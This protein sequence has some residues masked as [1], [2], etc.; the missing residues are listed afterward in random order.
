[1]L[2]AQG[3]MDLLVELNVRVDFVKHGNGSVK[4]SESALCLVGVTSLR[5][6]LTTHFDGLPTAASVV[7]NE[8]LKSNDC[9]GSTVR[10][11]GY[12]V[13]VLIHKYRLG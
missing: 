13:A 2:N 5:H 10:R 6:D 11:G 3:M 9:A 7:L 4:G 12:L 1:M 8:I